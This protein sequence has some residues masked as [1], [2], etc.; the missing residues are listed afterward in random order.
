MFKFDTPELIVSDHGNQFRSVV[1]QQF[2]KK[3][4]IKH[5]TTGVYHPQSNLSEASNKTVKTSIRTQIIE[6]DAEHV[7]WAEYFP[8]I[9]MKM[10][11]TPLTSTHQS[12][13]F[14]LHGRERAQTGNEHTIILD[15]N[16]EMTQTD[17]RMELIHAAD[18]NQSR[19]GFEENRKR[20]DTRS[21]VQKFKIGDSVYV[22]YRE[23][24]S[25][26]KKTSGK[27]NPVKRQ[28]T[29]A[30]VVGNDSYDLIDSQN[31]S[32]GKYNAKDIMIR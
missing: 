28:A 5:S 24:S 14:T 13:F 10:N 15:A 21:K 22:F 20:Y 11:S 9:T 18:A 7:D 26:A 25:A 31:R 16:P 29:I 6:K 19:T 8:F 12:P 2:L 30:K 17:E 1:F 32:L 23:L 4:K 27:L 3:Y